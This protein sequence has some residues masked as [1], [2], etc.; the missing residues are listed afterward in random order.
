MRELS[1]PLAGGGGPR[2]RQEEEPLVRRIGSW[3]VWWTVLMAFWVLLDDSIA[4][5][6][7]LAGAGAA[8]LGAFLAEAVQYQAATRFRM[9]IEWV[10]PAL[11]LPWQVLKDTVTVFRALW[12]RLVHGIEPAS[13]F[14]EVPEA[15]GDD[16][17]EGVTRRAL[18]V[19]GASVAPNTLSLG[20]DEAG[21]VMVV[22]RLVVPGDD[23]PASTGQREG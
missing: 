8:A 6:E 9:R 11:R 3:L 13:G 17:A 21:G 5:A 19:M 15:Y 20:I 12:D 14:A 1:G 23:Q 22:H 4:L 2:R 10:Q 16:T 18:M 7:L